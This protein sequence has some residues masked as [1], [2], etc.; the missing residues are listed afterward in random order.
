MRYAIDGSRL[1]ANTEKWSFDVVVV[2]AGLAGLY[3]AL[4]IDS[5]LS[6]CVLA[7]DE[8][9]TSNSWLAQGGIAAAI[10]A[11]DAPVF[12]VEDTM[13]AGAGLCDRA[14]VEVLCAEGPD[15]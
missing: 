2:G 11:D 7:K 6:V 3:T 5:R 14:A 10:S 13:T 9:G 4:N 15:D 12:H 8:L 1:G